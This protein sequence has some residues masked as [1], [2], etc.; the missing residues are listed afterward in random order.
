[1]I[2]CS[3]QIHLIILSALL[4]FISIVL[5][6]TIVLLGYQTHT[7]P[8]PLCSRQPVIENVFFT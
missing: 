3:K 5:T 8:L 1:M 6:T 7:Q 4:T 2:L